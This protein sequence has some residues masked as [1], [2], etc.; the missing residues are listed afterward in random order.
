[1]NVLSDFKERV[2]SEFPSS[3]ENEELNALLTTIHNQANEIGELEEKIKQL[4]TNVSKKTSA[5]AKPEKKT[6]PAV[7]ADVKP[8]TEVKVNVKPAVKK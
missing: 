5:K 2:E 8:R 1:M 4:E 3:I 6:A 7:K